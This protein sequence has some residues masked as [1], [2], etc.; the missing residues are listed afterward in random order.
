MRKKVFLPS[1]WFTMPGECDQSH[2]R[3]AKHNG[4]CP[5]CLGKNY[6]NP[7][8]GKRTEH[9]TYD[10]AGNITSTTDANGGTIT[11]RYNSMGQVHEVIDQEGTGSF[12]TAMKKAAGKCRLAG[13][14]MLSDIT[15]PSMER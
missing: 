9:Y 10:Y 6:R 14:E 4:L 15:I 3:R 11:Y 2:R 1:A 5:G 12:S 7:Y 8:P 13:M